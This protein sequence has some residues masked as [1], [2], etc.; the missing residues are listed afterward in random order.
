MKKSIIV[1]SFLLCLFMVSTTLAQ[2]IAVVNLEQIIKNSVAFKRLNESLEK[3]KNEYQG[4][5]KQKEIELNAKRDDLQSKASMFSQ[6]TLQQKSLEFQKDI[7][8]FQEEVKNKEEE[9]QKK[10]TYGLNTL[11]EEIN[12]IINDMSKEKDFIK[13]KTI[14]NSAV[15]LKYDSND[16]ITMEVLKRLN[17]KNISLVDKKNK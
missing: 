6:E 8:S 3:E 4:K 16:D 1:Y 12:K 7:L 13:Y 14:I 17:K 5:I 10:L 2:D 11:N 9:L 15:L